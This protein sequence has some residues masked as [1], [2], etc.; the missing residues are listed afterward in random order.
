MN[1][2]FWLILKKNSGATANSFLFFLFFLSMIFFAVIEMWRYR[3]ASLFF[4][5]EFVFFFVIE[6]WGEFCQGGDGAVRTVPDE[7]TSM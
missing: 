1:S 7:V 2:V 6:M 3:A 4:F 5:F